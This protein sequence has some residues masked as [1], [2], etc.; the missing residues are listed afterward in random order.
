M[1]RKRRIAMKL[2][3]DPVMLLGVVNTELRDY[4][5]SLEEFAK[6]HMVS[7]KEIIE[8]LKMIQYEYNKER[9]QFI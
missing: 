3:K 6:A 5:E 1:Q 2:P 8:K 7:E 9:N 4:Y